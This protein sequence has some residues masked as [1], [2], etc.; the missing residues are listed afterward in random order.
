MGV[1][2]DV[3]PEE[4]RLDQTGQQGSFCGPDWLTQVCHAKVK[5]CGCLCSPWR[6][7]GVSKP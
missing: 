3:T 7:H 1:F 2:D 4:D 6:S 5:D